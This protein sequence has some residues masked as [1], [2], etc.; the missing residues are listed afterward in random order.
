MVRAPSGTVR[1]GVLRAFRR[2]RLP[3]RL[4]RVAAPLVGV[5]RPPVLQEPRNAAAPPARL[6]V[7]PPGPLGL[8]VLPGRPP[9]PV[10]R[11]RRRPVRGRGP[12]RRRRRPRR[13]PRPRRRAR[14]RILEDGQET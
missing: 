8:A 2:P 14:V 9:G 5:Q 3:P 13:R 11:A 6:Q 4:R 10:P 7:V 1:G 12:P